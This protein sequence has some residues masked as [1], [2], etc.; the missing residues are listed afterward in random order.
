MELMLHSS[1]GFSSAKEP[2]INLLPVLQVV[3]AF[4]KTRSMAALFCKSVTFLK[5][6]SWFMGLFFTINLAYMSYIA[7]I[8]LI[9]IADLNYF[10]TSPRFFLHCHPVSDQNMKVLADGYSYTMQCFCWKYLLVC[11]WCLAR[12]QI[13]VPPASLLG[14]PPRKCERVCVCSDK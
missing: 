14:L 6:V 9:S 2:R 11:F 4:R 12:K 3:L 1:W 13:W 10:S 8:H 5:Y 7:I